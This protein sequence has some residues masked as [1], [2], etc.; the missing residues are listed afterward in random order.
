MISKAFFVIA[1]D[2]K[3]AAVG[4]AV[5][6][7]LADHPPK[8]DPERLETRDARLDLAQLFLSDCIDLRA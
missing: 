2:L 8:F 5:G 1:Q 3:D 7:A 4:H 6:A